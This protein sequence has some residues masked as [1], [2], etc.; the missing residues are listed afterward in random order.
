VGASAGGLEAL[1]A[2]LKAF[3]PRTGMA[4][5]VIQHL[6]PEHESVL[7]HLLSK[8]T[9]MPVLEVSEGMLIE[10]NHVYVI[11][12]NKS[13]IVQGVTLKLV[14]RE[15]TSVPHHPIDQFCSALAQERNSAA[16]GVILSGSGSD[17]TVGLKAIKA[18]GGVTFAQDPKTA[19]WQSMPMSAISAGA[20]DFV[21][22]PSGI[23][24]E[25]AR[26]GRHPYLRESGTAPE[27]DGLE[28]VYRLLRSATGVDFRLY[29][30]PTVSRR[31]A[32]RMALKKASSLDEY[33]QFLKQDAP[34]IKALADDVFIHVTGFFRDPDCF[35]ALRRRV[36]PTFYQTKRAE[37]IRVWVPGCSTGEEVYS[38]AMLLLESRR[39]DGGP[40]RIQMFGGA[41]PRRNLYRSGRS[42]RVRGAAE[43]LLS[44]G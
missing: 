23:A 8:V 9:A 43:T 5:V 13:M 32:R 33:V 27:G 16:I 38:V 17:G 28:S 19:A 35:Q 42:R 11:P 21:L 36:F 1:T 29:K 31:V 39:A 18:K 3:P 24:E 44:Q 40:T 4:V 12:P 7:S 37:P 25:L 34:E 6:A 15:R 2:V 41:R 22:P 26:I 20:V 30:Q 10:R 14:P